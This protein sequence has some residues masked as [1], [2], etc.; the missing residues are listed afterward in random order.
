MKATY[1]TPPKLVIFDCDGVIVD[2]VM[3]HCE[4]LANSFSKYGLN[5]TPEQCRDELGSGKMASIGDAATQLGARLPHDW[6]DEIYQQIYAR[7]ERGVPL[8]KG[9]PAV[10]DHL[11]NLDIPYCVAS[12]GSKEKM[13]IMLERKG[14]L[15]R[16]EGAIFSAHTINSWKPDPKLFQY[17]A[18][19]MKV[20]PKDCMV[21]EDSLTGV[22]AAKRAQMSCLAYSPDSAGENLKKEGAVVFHD[23][24]DLPNI[25]Q[26]S[27]A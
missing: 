12:N 19:T 26:I 18:D 5:L 24:Q 1:L 3:A 9:I 14:I 6:I 25:L 23:M 8:I 20:L 27:A 16:F 10:F 15:R 22:V 13:A 11:D 2:S 7:L 21:I 4:V 17:A